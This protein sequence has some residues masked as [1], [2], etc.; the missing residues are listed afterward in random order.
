MKYQLGIVIKP[1][2]TSTPTH[3]IVRDDSTL[4]RFYIDN[5]SS[6]VASDRSLVSSLVHH[7]IYSLPIER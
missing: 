2:E 7:L 1:V 5:L 3:P 6:V 4:Y